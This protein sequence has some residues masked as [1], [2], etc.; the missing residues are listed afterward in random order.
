MRLRAFS[1]VELVIVVVII[2]VIAA[3][4]VP[5]MSRTA[6]GAGDAALWGN[7][8][9]LRGVIDM[10]AAEHGG[11]YPGADEDEEQ[12][13]DQ[14]TKKTDAAGNVGTA[15]G[16]HIYG[17][18]LRRG[19]PPVPVGPNTGATGVILTVTIPLTVVVDESDTEYGWIYNYKTGEI[20][21]NTD[22]SDD[23]G[24]PYSSY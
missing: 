15:F 24:T 10:Y 3:I 8:A 5:R 6:K 2:G 22:D 4:A 1:L 13:I 9:T 19:F 11:A 14:L 21:A 23:S 16:V 17:P 7:L 12:L 20:I 18:Y